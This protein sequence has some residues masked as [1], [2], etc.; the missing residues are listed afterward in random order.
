MAGLRWTSHPAQAWP[1]LALTYRQRIEAGIVA[2]AQR[3]AP[4]IENY[5]KDNAPWTD[6]TGNARQGLHTEVNHVVGSMVQII[7][8]HGVEY[9]IWLEIKSAGAYAIVNPSLDHFAPLVW[10]DVVAM[11]R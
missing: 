1:A 7:L 10:R 9:G 4:E 5:M 6:R 2:I 11:L 3:W 8:S